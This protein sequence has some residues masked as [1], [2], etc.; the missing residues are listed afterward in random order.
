MDQ[1]VVGVWNEKLQKIDFKEIE[2]E[3]E[4]DE[5]DEEHDV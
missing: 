3:E 2:S 5:Y 1:D 4:E